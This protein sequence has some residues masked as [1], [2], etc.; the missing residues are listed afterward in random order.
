MAPAWYARKIPF[1]ALT[2]WFDAKLF[3]EQ[4]IINVVY[5]RF[6]LYGFFIWKLLSRDYRIMAFANE[7]LLNVYGHEAFRSSG[8]YI[9]LGRSYV[10]DIATFH[11]VHWFLPFPSYPVMSFIY[12]GAIALCLL[13]IVFGGGRY[14]VLSIASF[15]ALNYLWGYNWRTGADVDAIF[16]PLQMVLLF[17]VYRGENPPIWNIG[18]QSCVFTRDAGWLYSM[19]L[20]IIIGYYVLSGLNKLVD[21][22]LA[23]WF[24]YSL[25]EQLEQFRNYALVGGPRLVNPIPLN[26][27]DGMYWINPIAV[28]FIYFS[29]ITIPLMFFYRTTILKF[30]VVYWAFHFTSAGLTIWF[31]GLLIIWLVLLPVHRFFVPVTVTISGPEKLMQLTR[32]AIDRLDWWGHVSFRDQSTASR[33]SMTCEDTNG[34]SRSTGGLCLRRLSWT[35]PPLWPLLPLM[36]VP[37]LPQ[38]LFWLLSRLPRRASGA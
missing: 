17:A 13:N 6:V 32:A 7:Q 18:K 23:D 10:V 4:T 33:I 30:L 35:L 16:I 1:D 38:A 2:T 15:I 20:L 14:N 29:H 24:T 36:Y 21:I 26:I 22:T 19:C 28:S 12:F 34:P 8:N 27:V 9:F 11:W 3:H 37:F 31:S 5:I 25:V